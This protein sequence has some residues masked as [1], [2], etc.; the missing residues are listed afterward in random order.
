MTRKTSH[1]LPDN[2]IIVGTKYYFRQ[3]VPEE[4]RG[5]FCRREYR[6]SLNTGD[7]RKAKR[8]A[9][10]MYSMMWTMF[11]LIRKGDNVLN[12]YTRQQL[13][14]IAD[15]W[16]RDI[17][18]EDEEKRILNSVDH[19]FFFTDR[20]HE[21][22]GKDDDYDSVAS[23]VQND[24][25]ESLKSNDYQRFYYNMEEGQT[26]GVYMLKTY[27]DNVIATNNLNFDDERDYLL[28]AREIAKRYDDY[29][30]IGKAREQ[31]DYSKEQ[32]IM[33]LKYSAPI[34]EPGPL[35][36]QG[37]P[38]CASPVQLSAP[39]SL[40]SDENNPMLSEAIKSYYKS[41]HYSEINNRTQE[42]I[43]PIL[44]DFLDFVGDMKLTNISIQKVREFR[45]AYYKVPKER[46]TKKYK[47]KPLAKIIEIAAKDKSMTCRG[48]SATFRNLGLIKAF[49][50]WLLKQGYIVNG[51][52]GIVLTADRPSSKLLANQKRDG[53]TT[54]DL[55][56]MFNHEVYRENKYKHSYQYWLPL[57][58]AFTGARLNEL[59]QMTVNDIR[60]S[61]AKG[62]GKSAGGTW[63]IDINRNDGK[64]VKTNAGVRKIPIHDELIRLGFIKYV[65][66]RRSDKDC[67]L[68]FPELMNDRYD[69]KL[70]TKASRWF[71]DQF[72][73]QVGIESVAS[74][75]NADEQKKDFH[76][77]RHTVTNH[78]KQRM[79]D[80]SLVHEVIGH[81][82]ARG[83]SSIYEEAYSVD[84]L[85]REVV[86]KIEYEGIDFKALE[87]NLFNKL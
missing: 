79:V 24:I 56:A 69:G 17:L 37:L 86:D 43:K 16:L 54:E 38:L 36:T 51:Q 26:G 73:K 61:A 7:I 55:K 82:N 84:I 5:R 74:K 63:Y 12:K 19:E 78:L 66:S 85:K 46:R 9:Y 32:E 80:I 6:R 50:N 49:I 71:N 81:E 23:L 53:Y 47:G 44:A 28:L 40:Y 21:H 58:G 1:K 22:A 4:L 25:R 11:D 34:A 15:K 20:E 39:V 64:N 29:L 83:V 18:E 75:Q 87:G 76:S 2:I 62:D 67:T 27:I 68:V 52:I 65:D 31:G 41:R 45:D 8:K 35:G 57:L 33:K 3:V 72:R 10:K 48:A 70:Y 14:E 59:C 60:K 13:H 42:E 77:F 30:S